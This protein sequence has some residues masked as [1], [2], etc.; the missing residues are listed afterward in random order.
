[1]NPEKQAATS[2]VQT[3]TVKTKKDRTS[4]GKRKKTSNVEKSML[5]LTVIEIQREGDSEMVECQ[6]E[7]TTMSFVTFKFRT[8]EDQPD[9]IAANLVR[10][11]V[12]FTTH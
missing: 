5:R 11:Y 12:V 8:T 7:T 10:F 4:K 3:S 6:L 2:T 9:E 1:M